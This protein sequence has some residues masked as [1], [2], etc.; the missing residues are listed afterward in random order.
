[1]HM[2]R[3]KT[4]S[5]PV[6]K[7]IVFWREPI[8]DGYFLVHSPQVLEYD[9]AVEVD[10]LVRLANA[11]VSVQPAV[12]LAMGGISAGSVAFIVTCVPAEARHCL[13]NTVLYPAWGHPLEMMD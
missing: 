8:R 13:S 2:P 11:V 9:P 5:W 10:D 6:R 7:A 3:D 1:M 4:G 12:L